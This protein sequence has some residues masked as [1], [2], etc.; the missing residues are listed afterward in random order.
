MKI[1]VSLFLIFFSSKAFS[2]NP[3][4]PECKMLAGTVISFAHCNYFIE[5]EEGKYEGEANDGFLTG[6]STVKYSNGETFRGTLVN[7]KYEGYGKFE[8]PNGDL[9]LGD[10]LELF[11]EGITVT[12]IFKS[13][14]KLSV[15]RANSGVTLVNDN[16]I[17]I[18]GLKDGKFHGEGLLY[19][20]HESDNHKQGQFI[21]GIFN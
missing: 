8:F 2:L 18:G 13:V 20:I 5:D 14:T 1:L 17:Y 4:L 3:F 15:P 19:R 6:L 21:L 7:G 10:V 12:K 11:K 16:Q 9:L